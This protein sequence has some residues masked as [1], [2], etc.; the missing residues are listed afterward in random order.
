MSKGGSAIFFTV[1]SSLNFYSHGGPESRAGDEVPPIRDTAFHAKIT[2]KERDSL[3]RWGVVP[4]SVTMRCH[5]L[6]KAMWGE[7]PEREDLGL[8]VK[9]PLKIGQ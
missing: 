6:K 4:M 5:E 2:E 3:W 9:R 1:A 7:G 8:S